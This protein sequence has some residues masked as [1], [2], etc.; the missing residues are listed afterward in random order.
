MDSAATPTTAT[1]GKKQA[2]TKKPAKDL[3]AEERLA[4][5][6]NSTGRRE[7]A[8]ARAAAAMLEEERLKAN[9]HHRPL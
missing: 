1:A 8:R 4:E 9:D 2:K 3:T 6:N 7:D 5:S